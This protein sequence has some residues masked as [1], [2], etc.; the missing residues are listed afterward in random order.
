MPYEPYGTYHA[1]LSA[2]EIVCQY[3]VCEFWSVDLEFYNPFYL[4]GSHNT[5][6]FFNQFAGEINQVD[7]IPV[8]NR[9]QC[10]CVENKADRDS[11]YG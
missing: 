3:V 8:F 2:G 6:L 5:G 4:F 7:G 10:D 1:E 9:S 11:C